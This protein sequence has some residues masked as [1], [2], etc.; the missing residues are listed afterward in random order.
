M[1]VRVFFSLGARL[2]SGFFAKKQALENQ[3]TV[4]VVVRCFLNLS[5]FFFVLVAFLR[6]VE[7]QLILVVGMAG[8]SQ[9]FSPKV[10][11]GKLS[12]L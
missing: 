9:T 2:F 3:F 1:F 8:E 7:C 10:S 6:L 5:V 11:N 4:V 12:N